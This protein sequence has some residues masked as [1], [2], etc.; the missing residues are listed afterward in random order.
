[1]PMVSLFSVLKKH[2]KF[3]NFL[4][5]FFNTR[6]ERN[7]L[8]QSGI[9]KERVF[10]CDL[11]EHLLNSG[12]DVPLVLKS[13]TDVIETHGLVDGIYRLSGITSNIQKLRLV[14]KTA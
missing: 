5:T 2:G 6:P 7:Q 14:V 8:K 12:H 9:V 13:C 10:G 11:G 3:L 4:R 1:M